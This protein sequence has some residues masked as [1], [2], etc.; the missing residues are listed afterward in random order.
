MTKVTLACTP[1]AVE[2]SDF[3]VLVRPRPGSLP[4]SQL[5]STWIGNTQTGWG[6]VVGKVRICEAMSLSS[7]WKRLFPPSVSPK[8]W[9]EQ[10]RATTAI[11]K[12]KSGSWDEF[13]LG[14]VQRLTDELLKTSS[15]KRY[16]GLGG[17]E[18]RSD[19]C[20]TLIVLALDG[21]KDE[22]WAY[23]AGVVACFHV[24]TD[25]YMF[26]QLE[27]LRDLCD[28]DVN[29]VRR[30]QDYL[31][32]LL[33]ACKALPEYFHTEGLREMALN[34]LLVVTDKS[35]LPA[36][37]AMHKLVGKEACEQVMPLDF[38]RTTL[39]YTNYKDNLQ[40]TLSPLLKERRWRQVYD[41]LGGLDQLRQHE[42]ARRLLPYILPEAQIPMWAS[43]SP[44]TDRIS[45]W[46]NPVLDE[47]RDSLAPIFDLEGPDSG[48]GLRRRY[49][50]SSP[51]VF[52]QGVLQLP[53]RDNDYI[54]DHVLTVFDC[55]VAKGA[56]AIRLFISL[57]VEP[58]T[59]NWQVIEQIEAALTLDSP[60]DIGALDAY[61][62]A[63]TESDTLKTM[64]S[65]TTALH[66]LESSP[67]LRPVF[68]EALKLK[69]HARRV[70]YK[71]Q[72]HLCAELLD[73][74]INEWYAYQVGDLSHALLSSTWLHEGWPPAYVDRLRIVP[75]RPTIASIF[76]TMQTASPEL[77]LLCEE[78]LV[79]TLYSSRIS[80][81]QLQLE[82]VTAVGL[83]LNDTIWQTLLDGDNDRDHLRDLILVAMMQGFSPLE[84]TTCVKQADS[85]HDTFVREMRELLGSGNEDMVC[86]TL[87][88]FL[89]IRC[90]MR[91]PAE[92]WMRLLMHMMRRRSPGLHTRCAAKLSSA[93]WIAWTKHLALLFTRRHF[94]PEGG[95]GFTL[96]EFNRITMIKVGISRM[97]ST[98]TYSTAS[99]GRYS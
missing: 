86:V 24:V 74:N 17:V 84:A 13:P 58:K 22:L 64:P 43:W 63:I 2:T 54:L 56:E 83:A 99:T 91:R 73:G 90:G 21:F 38:V 93:A 18:P 10:I 59:L 87:A 95:M 61:V 77:R 34:L 14:E 69:F 52:G 20:H 36:I 39:Q 79:I 32:C 80:G 60:S 98:S 48:G 47:F 49:R 96:E 11:E 71:A 44:N 81:G 51:G 78:F 76:R 42:S 41:L 35:K 57:C 70:L 94:D 65:F 15:K 40:R 19:D 66:I 92:C 4:C 46:E 29:F 12:L 6:G 97:G 25:D 82:T 3:K 9:R 5:S 7:A 27:V 88:E 28:G 45:A 26:G 62:R 72:R 68:G 30:A 33:L 8:L 67:G 50:D 53:R 55:A 85:E 75:T 1:T 16:L 37:M 89:A 31:Q 23:A